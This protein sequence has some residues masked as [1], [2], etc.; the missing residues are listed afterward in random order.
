MGGSFLALVFLLGGM[1]LLSGL[2]K[3]IKQPSLDILPT[4]TPISTNTTIPH[5]L[6][7]GSFPL[8]NMTEIGTNTTISYTFPASLSAQEK[9][10][11][12][13]QVSP[14]TIGSL[15]WD[16]DTIV[17]TPGSPL[18]TNQK[19][20][21][22]LI[23]G[24]NQNSWSFTTS[25]VAIDPNDAAAE[26]QAGD[27]TFGKITQQNLSNYP[28][29]GS[30]PIQSSQYFVYF[31]VQQRKFLAT[32]YPNKKSTM[33]LQDQTAS[34]KAAISQQLSGMGIPTTVYPFVWTITPVSE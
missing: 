9:N 27:V 21:V 18:A 10:N 33:S 23:N 17:F 34:I 3:T 4:P 25:P 6:V 30:L 26:Q 15:S 1:I 16:N 20:T 7:G 31:N 24:Q 29:L 2:K 28:W 11:V 8:N 14:A 13:L 32:I 19:Y 5:A 22:T 12:S